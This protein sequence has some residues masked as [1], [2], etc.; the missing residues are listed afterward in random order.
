VAPSNTLSAHPIASTSSISSSHHL[1]QS[2]VGHVGTEAAEWRHRALVQEHDGG[3]WHRER[4]QWWLA[5]WGDIEGV[6]LMIGD[7]YKAG[8]LLHREILGM[9]KVVGPFK[10]HGLAN[11]AVE[12]EPVVC[13]ATWPDSELTGPQ[14]MLGSVSRLQGS[15]HPTLI[16]KVCLVKSVMNEV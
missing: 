5:A 13:D 1:H 15:H 10:P 6:R 12:C 7:G 9:C 11:R 4:G 16:Y 8:I 2:P 14:E 3:R